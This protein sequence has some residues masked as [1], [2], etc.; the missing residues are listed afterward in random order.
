MTP[1]D[2]AAKL[3]YYIYQ[4]EDVEQQLVADLG[5]GTGMLTCGLV[6]I[7]ALYTLGV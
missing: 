6:Y 2:L 3:L 7:G 4:H 5:V 1:P